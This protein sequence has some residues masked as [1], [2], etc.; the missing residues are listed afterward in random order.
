MQRG[1]K[2][3]VFE[4]VVASGKT[5]QS[6]LLHE[7]LAKKY[8]K[9][10]VVWTREPGGSE[11]ADSI[12]QVVQATPF[13]EEMEPICEAYLYAA[14]RAQTLR[15]VVK[16]ILQKDGIVVADRSFVTSLAFQGYG[17]GVDTKSL[18]KIN[19]VAIQNFIP[20]LVIYMDLPIEI[21]MQRIIDRE[22]D[23]FESFGPEFFRKVEAGYA[24]ISQMKMFNNSWLTIDGG[25][26]VEKVQAVIRHSV[27][28]HLKF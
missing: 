10:Q 13:K 21:A 22:G 25:G 6:K 12:R 15:S 2:Y 26:K 18:L 16:P 9:K 24:E 8:P 14:S 20:D 17:R 27:E 3:I 7:F 11:I 19:A 4:G 28:H 5:T 23:K 1:G